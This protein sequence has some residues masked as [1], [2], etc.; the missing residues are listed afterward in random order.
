MKPSLLD[1]ARENRLLTDLTVQRGQPLVGYVKQK[2]DYGVFIRVERFDRR[3]TE[4]FE[5]FEPFEFFQNSGIF[6]RKFKISENFNI[7]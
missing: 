6:P 2:A 7:F 1:A 5:P 4:P 3:G